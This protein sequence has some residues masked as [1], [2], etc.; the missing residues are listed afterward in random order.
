[1]I[2]PKKPGKVSRVLNGAAK[3]H[4]SSLN[5]ALLVGPD[6]LQNLLAVLLRFRQHQHVVSADIEGMFL[7]VG[8]LPIDQLSLRFLWR[9]DSTTDVVTYQ[10]TRHIFGARDSPT[11][12][13]FALQKTARDNQVL[14]PDA[15][16]AV[17]QKFYMDDYLDSFHEPEQALKLSK[18]LVELLKLTKLASNVKEIQKKLCTSSDNLSQVKEI[19][20]SED[21]E[22]H[23]LGLKWDHVLDTLVVS[24]GVNRELKDT[25]T[26]RTVLS[27]VS[28]VFD[29]LG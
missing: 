26:Q 29:L 27:F 5:K 4:G 15:V 20:S 8:V 17:M 23:V 21:Q 14:F 9:E 16:S 7:R 6:L 12:A 22:S 10:Y 18:D 28:S 1:M 13:N 19:L 25:V 11:C 3:F 2:N 24:R